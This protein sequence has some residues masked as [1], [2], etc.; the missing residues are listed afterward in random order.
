MKK[1]EGYKCDYCSRMSSNAGAMAIHEKACRHN[2]S[3]RRMC[4]NCHWISYPDETQHFKIEEEYTVLKYDLAIMDCRYYGK[5]YAKLHGE[6]EVM[7]QDEGWMK[8]PSVAMGC[9][10]HLS[11]EDKN[12]IQDWA[13]RNAKPVRL[14][15]FPESHLAPIFSRHEIEV[16]PELAYEYFKAV[17][18][19]E[20]AKRF[21][22]KYNEGGV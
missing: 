3:N 8:M 17:G 1:Q 20:D 14:R 19:E 7:V 22:P 15:S 6:L 9:V 10:H 13:R 18:R 16:T 12:L 21:E 5:M 11:Y 2:P 4:D